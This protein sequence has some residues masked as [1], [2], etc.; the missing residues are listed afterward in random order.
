MTAFRDR[1]KAIQ[2]VSMRL[3]DSSRRKILEVSN[4]SRCLVE[5]FELYKLCIDTSGLHV[6]LFG[7]I[8]GETVMCKNIC[9]HHVEDTE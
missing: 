1:T 6:I 2:H 3:E 8:Y 9:S 5:T 7:V 4:R